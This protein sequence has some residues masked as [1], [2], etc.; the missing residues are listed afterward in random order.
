MLQRVRKQDA[1]VT[2]WSRPDPLEYC[3]ELWKEWM[4]KGGCRRAGSLV[5][6]GLVGDAD[7][8][9]HDLHEAQHSHDMQVAAAVDAMVDSL[10]RIH[11]WAIYASCSIATTWRFPHANL[12][13][14]AEEARAALVAKLKKNEC[15]R[16]FF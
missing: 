5:M 4:Q 9:G 16:N 3:L 7:G 15:T 10:S 6:G 13:L 14:T 8:H 12:I 11:V 2:A 1:K